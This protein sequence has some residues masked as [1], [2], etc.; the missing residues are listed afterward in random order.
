[1][2]LVDV[3]IIIVHTFEQR[4]VRQTLRSLRRAA[5]QLSYEVIIVDNRPFTGMH[6]ILKSEFPE[7]RYT[8][9]PSNRGF[10]SAMNAGIK[11]ASGKYILIFNPD[12]VVGVGSLE[13][14]F[15]YMEANPAVG[16]VGPRL[17]NPD[18]SLQ[19]SCYR[20]HELLIP[21]YRRTPLGRL[22]FAKRAINNFLMVDANHDATQEVDWLMGSALFTRRT[23]L[24]QAGPFD[25]RFFMYFEDTDL[26]RRFWQA[27]FKVI[28]HPAVSM[29]H[30]HR[31]AS[32]DGSLLRQLLA[33]LTREHIKSALRYFLKY[34]GQSNPRYGQPGISSVSST[35][36]S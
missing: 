32:S 21:A 4:L 18:G 16:I 36:I 26:C 15:A 7:A 1:M 29:V 19:H 35:I 34:R 11:L 14:L 17:N 8:A 12:I 25:D 13:A 22:P 2:S 20:Y 10:G 27:G 3:S 31:R 24:D 23:A 5:P 6:E 33:P 30:Y 28:Y 9:M